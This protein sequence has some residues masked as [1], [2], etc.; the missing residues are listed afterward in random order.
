MDANLA[1]I[2]CAIVAGFVTIINTIITSKKEKESKKKIEKEEEKVKEL[3]KRERKREELEEL[4]SKERQLTMSLLSS[5]CKLS[6]VTAKAV[7]NQKTNGDVE[8]AFNSAAE[9]QREYFDF[10]NELASQKLSKEI[11][12]YG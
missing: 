1:S 6:T 11:K 7:F 12:K 9:S 4:H 2:V 5:V 3:E 10:I 8:D